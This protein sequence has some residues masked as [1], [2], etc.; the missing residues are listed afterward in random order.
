MIRNFYTIPAKYLRYSK[1]LVTQYRLLVF[2]PFSRLRQIFCTRPK[3]ERFAIAEST[4][5]LSIEHSDAI[6]RLDGKQKPVSLSLCRSKQQ[7]TV[8]SLGFNLNS[9]ILFETIK[10][11]LCCISFSFPDFY[12]FQNAK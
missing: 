12:R 2:V 5:F 9:K 4:V 1:R 11:F 7:Y 10:K 3:A 8:K 6:I